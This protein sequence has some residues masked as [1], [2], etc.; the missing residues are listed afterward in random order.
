MPLLRIK[1]NSSI[2]LRVRKIEENGFIDVL[3]KRVRG[4]RRL[5]V[6]TNRLVDSLFVKTSGDEKP[7]RLDDNALSL[8]QIGEKNDLAKLS[9]K[10]PKPIRLDEPIITNN[11]NKDHLNE[12]FNKFWEAYP[13][14]KGKKPAKDIWMRKINPALGEL[15]V[16]DVSNRKRDRQWVEGYTPN[17]T[18]Y[19]NQER[20]N[21]EISVV[22]SSNLDNNVPYENGK[23]VNNKDEEVKV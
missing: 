10:N 15:I 5:F 16:Q 22:K 12:I 17:P 18:T 2:A 11:V 4:H 7:I 14:K 23:Y 1:A 8:K 19:L 3:Q 21:D 6:K 9:P 13:L 20:W